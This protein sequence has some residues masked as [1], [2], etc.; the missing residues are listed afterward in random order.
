MVAIPVREPDHSE[1]QGVHHDVATTL[2]VVAAELS[3]RNLGVD[4]ARSRTGSVLRL[5]TLLA[6][7]G[8]TAGIVIAVGVL[9]IAHQ[10]NGA[11][12]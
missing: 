12:R 6:V 4:R 11:G 7:T 8:L 9:L 10:L 3:P 2:G 5:V 1:S